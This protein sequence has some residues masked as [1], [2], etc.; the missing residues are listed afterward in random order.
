MKHLLQIQ[1]ELPRWFKIRS[2]QSGVKYVRVGHT[3]DLPAVGKSRQA[4]TAPEHAGEE[5]AGACSN[6]E[7]HPAGSQNSALDAPRKEA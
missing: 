7:P 6:D 2:D 1:K 4:K 3:L 5:P